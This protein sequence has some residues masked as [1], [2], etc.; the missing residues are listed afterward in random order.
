MKR[1]RKFLSQIIPNYALP[2]SFNKLLTDENLKHKIKTE[3]NLDDDIFDIVNWSEKQVPKTTNIKQGKRFSFYVPSE[4]LALLDE[5]KKL[6]EKTEYKNLSSF[7]VD[8]IKDKVYFETG[9][10]EAQ[11]GIIE[12]LVNI[13]SLYS[14]YQKQTEKPMKENQKLAI[15]NTAEALKT[16]KEKLLNSYR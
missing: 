8:A 2:G 13:Y 9:R 1:N 12:C 10:E 6:S 7:I 3:F 11:Q 15:R 16:Y 14:N 4:R 5:A